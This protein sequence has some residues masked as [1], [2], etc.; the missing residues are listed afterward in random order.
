MCFGFCVF[1]LSIFLS[2]KSLP[3]LIKFGRT[4]NQI[5]SVSIMA[6]ISFLR[7]AS[8]FIAIV[9]CLILPLT[10][11][12]VISPAMI[13][14]YQ[15][16][17]FVNQNATTSDQQP[18]SFYYFEIHVLLFHIAIISCSSFVQLYLYFKLLM[19]LIGIS[20]YLV[21]FQLQ[22]SNQLMAN[23]VQVSHLFLFAELLIQLFFFVLFLHLIDRRVSKIFTKFRF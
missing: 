4:Q 9:C 3:K 18:I 23:S 20:I 21:G 17:T 8:S 15:N 5:Q 22:K 10:V 11:E 19:M 14:Q 16:M 7:Y 6:E 12:W 13:G 2:L 1:S